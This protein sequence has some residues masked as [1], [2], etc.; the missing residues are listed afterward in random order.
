MSWLT[1]SAVDDF[2]KKITEVT[3]LSG[4]SSAILCDRN[5]RLA[6]ASAAVCVPKAVRNT[7]AS[8][9][10][11]GGDEFVPVEA[12]PGSV[13][14][15]N[16]CGGLRDP[17][18]T[19]CGKRS[20]PEIGLVYPWIRLFADRTLDQQ[21]DWDQEHG[22][23]EDSSDAPSVKSCHRMPIPPRTQHDHEPRNSA[24]GHR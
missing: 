16:A 1:M 4:N 22:D 15:L 23:R 20:A 7:A 5:D 12:R 17:D 8:D 21:L 10:D 11:V 24:L 2:Q 18:T 14:E 19:V 3:T 13:L 9:N 6:G